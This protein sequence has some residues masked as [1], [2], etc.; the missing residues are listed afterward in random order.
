ML[1]S[2]NRDHFVYL[3]CLKTTILFVFK[4]LI[5]TIKMEAKIIKHVWLSLQT[6]L[7]IQ[8]ALSL[9]P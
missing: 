2:Q 9:R 5:S 3:N 1:F 4:E 6:Y 8:E 7:V